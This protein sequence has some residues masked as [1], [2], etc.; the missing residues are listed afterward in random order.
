MMLFRGSIADP[1]VFSGVDDHSML[2]LVYVGHTA[3]ELG[4]HFIS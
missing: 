2:L 4:F 3:L 1:D